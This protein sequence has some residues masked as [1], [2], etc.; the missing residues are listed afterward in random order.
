M[1]SVCWIFTRQAT[2]GR[3]NSRRDVTSV[4]PKLAILAF[5][6]CAPA[7]S[8]RKNPDA[9]WVHYGGDAG[10]SRHS[11][12]GEIRKRSV[13]RLLETWRI[14]IAEFPPTAFEP[15]SPILD[16][17]STPT[18]VNRPCQRCT[19]VHARFETTPAMQWGKLFVLTPTSRVLALD[20]RNGATIWSYDPQVPID[21][22]YSEGLT[23]RGVA[24]WEGEQSE[25]CSRRVLYGTVNAKLIAL[26]ATNGQ[27]C[28]MFGKQGVVETAASGSDA[29]RLLTSITSPPTIVGDVAIVG[30][31]FSNS[32]AFKDRR[33]SVIAYDV[34]SGKERWSYPRREAEGMA[35]LEQRAVNEGAGARVWSIITA[36]PE[37]DMVF[38]PTASAEPNYAG[39]GRPGPNAGASSVVALRASTGEQIWEFQAVHHDLWDYDVAA[40]PMLVSVQRNGENVPAVVVGTK[41]GVIFVLDRRTGLPLYPVTE[42]RVPLS[43]LVG[44][45]VSPTQPF[46]DPAFV[47]HS[48]VLSADSAFGINDAERAGCRTQL[49]AMRNEGLFTPP[50]LTETLQWPGFWGGIN[51]DGMA[52]DPESS[53]IFVALKRLATAVVLEPSNT[54]TKLQRLPG[55]EF[56]SQGS[57]GYVA[58]RR[59]V[60]SALGVPCSPPP[61]SELIALGLNGG[62]R[63]L[64]RKPL[65]SVPWLNHLEGSAEWGSLTFGGALVTGG[66]L[67]FIASGQD[68]ILRAYDSRTGSV[69][70][71][72]KL[73]AGGQAAPMTYTLDGKQYIVIA[74]GGRGNVGTPGDW[75]V[76]FSLP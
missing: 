10:A 70:W 21:A 22:Y 72:A 47:L 42:R 51:W 68:D 13:A 26:D 36:D 56:F 50:G 12:A 3:G 44:E 23:S 18:V 11:V 32:V 37:R 15:P 75:I 24:L 33:A 58:R 43:T 7:D 41:S 52:W 49:N 30:A 1:P 6:C 35:T 59:P 48:H 65:G 19:L 25:I 14:R 54:P 20:P 67:L 40:P 5:V 28:A 57:T 74:A 39:M 73:P 63:E 17:A 46:A 27:L 71:S 45:E 9:D 66:G 55:A 53:T 60:L 76:A 29:S 61:W 34:R 38:L 8:T 62:P 16:D 4:T 31:T 69:L 2:G 64:W